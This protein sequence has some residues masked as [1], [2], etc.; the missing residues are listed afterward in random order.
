MKKLVAGLATLL[1]LSSPSA[2]MREMQGSTSAYEQSIVAKESVPCVKAAL[3]KYPDN[4]D[5]INT[6]RK[7][8]TEF[9]G[10]IYNYNISDDEKFSQ[11]MNIRGRYGP[12]AASYGLTIPINKEFYDKAGRERPPLEGSYE[13]QVKVII[14]EVRWGIDY[15]AQSA[16]NQLPRVAKKRAVTQLKQ[17]LC[18]LPSSISADMDIAINTG[19]DYFKGR[20]W[21]RYNLEYYDEGVIQIDYA[22]PPQGRISEY[23]PNES[24]KY[25]I[26]TDSIGWNTAVLLDKNG[27]VVLDNNGRTTLY[28][29][30]SPKALMR[31]LDAENGAGDFK[32]NR[33]ARMCDSVSIDKIEFWNLVNRVGEDFSGTLKFRKN[34]FITERQGKQVNFERMG[35]R[36]SSP[37]RELSF[38]TYYSG[39]SKAMEEHYMEAFYIDF[40]E[41]LSFGGRRQVAHLPF[42]STMVILEERK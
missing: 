32:R 8:R 17:D 22:S 25:R 16:R 34:S 41:W 35:M 28:T 1:Y 29:A 4:I 21:P 30:H 20:F 18:N 9:Q 24:T 2:A 11:Y 40:N 10:V 37:G 31:Y 19:R 23:S 38:A 39:Q 36:V 13:E 6:S 33:A 15:N 3:S 14:N 7:A 12:C 27:N 42:G 26:A 5:F